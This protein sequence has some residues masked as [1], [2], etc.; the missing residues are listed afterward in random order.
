[1][2]GSSGGGPPQV[3]LLTLPSPQAEGRF[4]SVWIVRINAASRELG[5]G[6]SRLVAGMDK[7]GITLD[8]KIPC[9]PGHQRPQRFKKVVEAAKAA[10]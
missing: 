2:E 8:R 7:Q 1:M 6:Y 10:S 4:P 9:G 3:A 5:V